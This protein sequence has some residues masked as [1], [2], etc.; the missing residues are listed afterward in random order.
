[1]QIFL[2]LETYRTGIAF[3]NEKVITIGVKASYED[4]ED[5]LIWNEWDLGNEMELITKFYNFLNDRLNEIDSKN[6]KFFSKEKDVLERVFVYGFNITRFDIPLLIQKGVEYNINDLPDMNLMWG[7]LIV[8]DY[9]QL[10]LTLNRM[11]Y[12]GL[13]WN[14]FA[15]L[16]VKAGYKVPKIEISGRE[17]KELYENGD[18]SKIIDRVNAKL[19]VLYQASKFLR[20]LDLRWIYS[21]NS[22]NFR[23]R[24]K[25]S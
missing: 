23:G 3:H 24:S 5:T 9:L 16:L 10:L 20:S 25:R 13:N 1:M 6:L 17:I 21:G 22:R 14:N 19:E 15:R 4:K 2:T 11:K 7:N 12:H 8:T 18:Y